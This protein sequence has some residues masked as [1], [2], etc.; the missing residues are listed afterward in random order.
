MSKPKYAIE[1]TLREKVAF[2]GII[3]KTPLVLG[4]SKS[5]DIPLPQLDFLSRQ[6]L[7]INLVG[8]KYFFKDLGSSNGLYIN[9][10]KVEEGEIS[11]DTVIT[12][13]ALLVKF[14]KLP[15][16]S[17][18]N[19]AFEPREKTVTEISIHGT[20]EDSLE[21][22]IH[23][24]KLASENFGTGVSIELVGTETD[25]GSEGND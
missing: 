23:N 22:Q 7:E 25:P 16:L 18:R 24:E 6:H 14:R 19:A 21:L 13:G 11:E 1:V 8:G 15:D 12:I 20:F 9:E 17:K 4:R 10:N 3:E 5:C 2:R